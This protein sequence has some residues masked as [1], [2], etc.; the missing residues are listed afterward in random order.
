VEKCVAQVN[1]R[2]AAENKPI[3]ECGISESH[4]EGR[5][6]KEMMNR[7]LNEMEKLK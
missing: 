3:G 5:G 1:P 7:N 6:M 2:T 4:G